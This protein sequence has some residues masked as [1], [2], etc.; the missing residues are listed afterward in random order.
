MF[1]PPRAIDPTRESFK[2]MFTAVPTGTTVLMLN[3]IRFREIAVDPAG[4]TPCSG[5]E[6]YNMYLE[7]FT[8]LIKAAGGRM[9]WT[10]GT[11]Y[12]LIAA[13]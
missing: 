8:P 9:Y 7:L 13:A 4:S 3:L 6:A 12:T 10:A 2:Q 5:R 1:E 11:Y